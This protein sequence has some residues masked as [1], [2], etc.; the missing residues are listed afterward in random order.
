LIKETNIFSF[1]AQVLSLEKKESVMREI[2]IDE[3][4]KGP[5]IGSMFVAGVLNFKG[6][7]EM[8]VKDSK[9]LRPAKREYLAGK[10]EAATKVHVFELSAAEID[11]LRDK[12]TM[13]EILVELFSRV[14][15][16][17][18]P[19]KAFVDAADVNAERF[20]ANLRC[21][22]ENEY[23]KAVEIISRHKADTHY[24]IVSA[25]SIIAKVHRDRSIRRIEEEIGE[26]IGSGYPADPLTIRF[27][28]KKLKESGSDV[29]FYVRRSWK[30]V[31]KLRNFT[32]MGSEL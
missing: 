22:S 1:L 25:A 29:P 7:E 5:V 23:G 9:K 10:I 12:C 28:E 14:I 18:L 32:S 11:T 15:R 13:N 6:L 3:A 19:D 27:L 31:K 17:F 8:G 4:G 21:K 24:P 2:G 20:G 30:T 26:K 16:V